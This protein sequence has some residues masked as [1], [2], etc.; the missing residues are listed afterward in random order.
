MDGWMENVIGSLDPNKK[1]VAVLQNVSP[2]NHLLSEERENFHIPIDPC[3]NGR[4]NSSN[5]LCH[6]SFP[7]REWQRFAEH[8]RYLESRPRLDGSWQYVE[9]R[10]HPIRSR[11]LETTARTYSSKDHYQLSSPAISARWSVSESYATRWKYGR[12]PRRSRVRVLISDKDNSWKS[13]RWL[14]ISGGVPQRVDVKVAWL[15]RAVAPPILKVHI[16]LSQ[17]LSYPILSFFVSIFCAEFSERPRRHFMCARVRFLGEFDLLQSAESAVW[18]RLNAREI[19]PELGPFD[20]D[21]RTESRPYAAYEAPM[22][23]DTHPE[24][25]GN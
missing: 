24:T 5:C 11:K 3:G 21:V 15:T 22:F 6:R 8:L 18:R 7:L 4:S 12:R 2:F 20:V 13:V 23:F 17:L 14:V 16:Y 10:L 25:L 1:W 19:R 9:N